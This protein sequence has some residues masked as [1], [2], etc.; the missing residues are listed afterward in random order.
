MTV[1]PLEL[2]APMEKLAFSRYFFNVKDG[3]EF[4]DQ[5]GTEISSMA[6]VRGDAI[7]MAGRMIGEMGDAFWGISE[8]TMTVTDEAGGVVLTLTFAGR[9][10]VH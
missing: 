5:E 7:E 1:R 6:E 8:W 3:R 10:H 4:I 9:Q 2:P